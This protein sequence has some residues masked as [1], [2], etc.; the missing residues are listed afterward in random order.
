[1]QYYQGSYTKGRAQR[2]IA[3]R[4]YFRLGPEDQSEPHESL[5]SSFCSLLPHINHHQINGE[6]HL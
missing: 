1:M 3:A 2:G 5:L 4:Q 6:V